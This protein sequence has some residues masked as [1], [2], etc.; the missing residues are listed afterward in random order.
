MVTNTAFA[1]PFDADP[2]SITEEEISGERIEATEPVDY[3]TFEWGL[4]D[5]EYEYPDRPEPLPFIAGER[6]AMT[7]YYR[8]PDWAFNGNW[9]ETGR[10]TDAQLEQFNKEYD[11]FTNSGLLSQS[12]LGE[13]ETLREGMLTG[14]MSPWEVE[15][16]LKY[17]RR[18]LLRRDEGQQVAED[19]GISYVNPTNFGGA[20]QYADSVYIG[21]LHNERKNYELNSPEYKELTNLIAQGAPDFQT[22][23][24]F[25]R[26]NNAGEDDFFR[27]A[28]DAQAATM[29]DYLNRNDIQLSTGRSIAAV[30]YNNELITP[31]LNT[32]T[33]L[34]AYM[35]G[36]DNFAM[37]GIGDYNI[38]GFSDP[39]KQSTFG[40]LVNVGLQIASIMNPALAPMLTG[41]QAL[42]AG[43]DLEDAL[44]AGAT[45]WAGQNLTKDLVND[46]L[47]D[48]GITP[49]SLNLSE[50]VFKDYVAGTITDVAVGGESL[51]E[52]LQ[53]ALL[54]D[55]GDIAEGAVDWAKENFPSLDFDLPEFD[56][57]EGI[58]AIGNFIVDAGSA[59][60]RP[61]EDAVRGAGEALE[62]VVETI[63]DA[64]SAIGRPI[65]DALSD[66]GRP[67]EDAVREV[68]SSAED[69]VR[70]VG[71]FFEPIVDPLLDALGN[72]NI[73]TSGLAGVNM[74]G[75]YRPPASNIP[76]QVEEMFSDELF[77]F[78]TEIGISDQPYFEYEEFFDNDLMPR[79][80]QPRTYSF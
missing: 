6:S 76:T 11:I 67:I 51:E 34:N 18:D 22:Q 44:K 53:D 73:N 26:Y 61:I 70:E 59:I 62:P 54:S 35:A 1:S 30:P 78:E 4:S 43:G 48:V 21:T 64:G 60:G 2:F 63:V 77:K 57:P 42:V 69:A 5:K 79:R 8:P 27:I 23:A 29:Q 3:S 25:Q 58:E 13:L 56:T 46:T 75:T 71:E 36:R 10:A 39:K 80:Q 38:I 14:S 66:I 49:E 55:A 72:V 50:D 24:E 15:V 68:G 20:K 37:G 12:E 9:R 45:S 19:A 65:E 74:D 28:S 31:H 16:P 52:S 7:S 32:G 40:R 41:A 33:A 47:K 17:F